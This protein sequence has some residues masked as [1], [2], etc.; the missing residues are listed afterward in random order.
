M[1][2]RRTFLATATLSALG[3]PTLLRRPAL[4]E[5][6]NGPENRGI[7]ICA[8]GNLRRIIP[9][10]MVLLSA[11][12]SNAEQTEVIR[13]IVREKPEL[14]LL[15]GDQVADGNNL[16]E[17]SYYDAITKPFTEAGKSVLVVEYELSRAQFCE[18]ARRIGVTAMRKHLSLD[19][20]RRPC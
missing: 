8:V 4:A 11:R 6:I 20:W 3:L 1:L 16:E 17:W 9:S 12:S 7:V 13:Q 10:E 19:A 5:S 18:R 2:N 15:L 14:L